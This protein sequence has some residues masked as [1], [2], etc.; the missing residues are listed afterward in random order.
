M[1]FVQLAPAARGLAQFVFIR[2]NEL[3][4]GPVMVVVAVKVTAAEV[5]FLI[6]IV[7]VA[8]LVPTVVDGNV[9]EPGVIVS[10]VLAL[11]PVPLNATVCA[12]ED[13]ESK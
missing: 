13:A 12:V 6:V 4:F 7:C 1:T 10:P 8:A 9:N 11:A 2:L 3:A 5:L